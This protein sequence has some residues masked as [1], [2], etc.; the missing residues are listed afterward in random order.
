MRSP[1]RLSICCISAVFLLLIGCGSTSNAAAPMPTATVVPTLAPTETPIPTA[2]PAPTVNPA[3]AQACFGKNVDLHSVGQIGTVLF[4]V[5]VGVLTYP[6]VQLPVGIPLK[7][8]RLSGTPW[9]FTGSFVAGVK[10]NPTG[11]PYASRLAVSLCTPSSTTA[12]LQSLRVKLTD[13]A[14]YTDA[15][16]VWMP[17]P[18]ATSYYQNTP[19]KVMEI[20]GCGGNV[21]RDL[22]A[23]ATL[24]AT[25][26]GTVA[27][28]QPDGNVGSFPLTLKGAQLATIEVTLPTSPGFYSLAVVA[29][30]DGKTATIATPPGVKYLYAPVTHSWGGRA[31]TASA[32][33]AQIPAS[34]VG[35]YLCP[36]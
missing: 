21:P 20:A 2:T 1:R 29:Q 12:Q 15:L 6:A 17:I 4:H 3:T 27:A 35:N 28:A 30:I 33:L 32:M 5:D 24:S 31:C 10:V 22:T 19:A 16:D 25:T 9:D 23:K 8:Y 7:P 36:N 26:S 11:K 34:P 13:F 14:P 18:C